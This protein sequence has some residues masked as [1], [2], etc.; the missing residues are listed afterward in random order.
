M[1]R[2]LSHGTSCVRL[3]ARLASEAFQRA[4]IWLSY[5]GQVQAL[6]FFLDEKLSRLCST[7]VLPTHEPFGA[8][9]SART[10]FHAGVERAEWAQGILSLRA[11]GKVSRVT[12][13]GL[14]VCACVRY[15]P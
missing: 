7:R 3:S 10:P 6:L 2:R 9:P 12:S 15:D 5:N 1:G 13:L 14:C 4:Q 11:L 8:M